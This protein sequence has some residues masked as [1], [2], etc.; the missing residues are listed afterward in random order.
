V[1]HSQIAYLEQNSL[2]YPQI[3]VKGSMHLGKLCL[4]QVSIYLV[5]LNPQL[6]AVLQATIFKWFLLG[7]AFLVDFNSS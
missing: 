3:S 7:I 1:R 4:L 2:L 6:D 5:N